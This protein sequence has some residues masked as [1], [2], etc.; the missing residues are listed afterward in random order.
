MDTA[1]NILEYIDVI[2]WI[3]KKGGIWINLG[4]LLYHY[5]DL[6][7]EVQLELPWDILQKA[8]K[9]KFSFAEDPKFLKLGYTDNE[10][11][12]FHT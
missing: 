8:I 9:E 7:D 2:K 11:S 6:I 10:R 3:L 4:P 1:H 5:T 12:M